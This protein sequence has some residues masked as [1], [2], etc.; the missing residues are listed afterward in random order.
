MQTYEVESKE[1]ERHMQELITK[2]PHDIAA[3]TE[4][5]QRGELLRGELLRA[6]DYLESAISD[7]LASG[8]QKDGTA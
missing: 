8:Q 1:H 3:H 2:S 7:V 5:K 4:E 6:G